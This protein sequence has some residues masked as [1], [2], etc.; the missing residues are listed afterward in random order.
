MKVLHIVSVADA[1]SVPLDFALAFGVRRGQTRIAAFSEAG[2]HPVDHTSQ[3]VTALGAKGAFD[4][5]AILR[6]RRLIAT[7]RPDVLHL[8]HAISAF[9]A[10]LVTWTFWTRPVVIKTEH[11]DHRFQPLHHR[12]IHALIYPFL[13]GIV[14]NSD[15]TLASFSRFERRL[16]GHKARRIYNGLNLSRVRSAVPFGT[17]KDG[18]IRIGHVARLVAQKNQTR[19]IHAFA[20]AR[21]TSGKDMR[22]EIVGDGPLSDRLKTEARNVGVADTVTFVGPLARDGVYQKLAEWDGFIMPSTFEGFC[23]AVVEAI[24]AGLPV[25]VSDIDTLQ[26]VV[27]DN[28]LRFDPDDA[29]A[30]ADAIFRLSDMPKTSGHFADR[31]DMDHTV[32]EHAAFYEACASR[33]QPRGIGART[34]PGSSA[35]GGQP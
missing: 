27:G 29:D 26:E 25:A 10:V 13:H 31:Y 28:A 12:L 4:G 8:H 20:K 18:V 7:E 14:C 32:S 21:K 35:N 11:N 34:V 16:A 1:Q 23:N 3:D 30:M 33:H 19:L 5:R 9:W 24:A 2:D 22:L 15:T 17:H 6:L